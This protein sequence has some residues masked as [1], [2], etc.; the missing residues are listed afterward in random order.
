MFIILI[1]LSI[2]ALVIGVFNL[3]NATLGAGVI[4]IACFF[5]ILARIEQAN[6]HHKELKQLLSPEEVKSRKLLPH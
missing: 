3:T 6:S 4:A 5:A 2:I 1:I